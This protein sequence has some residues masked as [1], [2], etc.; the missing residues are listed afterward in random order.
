MAAAAMIVF[1]SRR[2]DDYSIYDVRR[3]SPRGD[4][5]FGRQSMRIGRP[6]LPKTAKQKK[7]AAQR[8]ARKIQRQA[9]RK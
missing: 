1:D 7:R 4:T 2:N 5:G 8:D 9:A 6:P 3:A